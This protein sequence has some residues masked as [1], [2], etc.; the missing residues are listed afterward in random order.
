MAAGSNA[1]KPEDASRRFLN[2][3]IARE[4]SEPIDRFVEERVQAEADAILDRYRAQLDQLTGQLQ[5]LSTGALD[6]VA[7]FRSASAHAA[8]Q[9]RDDAERDVGSAFEFADTIDSTAALNAYL[10]A[11]IE[12]VFMAARMTAA[13]EIGPLL[14]RLLPPEVVEP[15]RA[16]AA[17]KTRKRRA[18]QS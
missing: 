11:R 18:S 3:L 13:D 9:L 4:L 1:A 17:P 2:E 6:A 14:T 10:E 16:D 12:Q 5:A 15:A 7:L 8:E